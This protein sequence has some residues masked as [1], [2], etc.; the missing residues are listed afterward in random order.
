MTCCRSFVRADAV[1]GKRLYRGDWTALH[2]VPR[3]AVEDSVG[4]RC[5][6][7]P[8]RMAAFVDDTR[9]VASLILKM[10]QGVQ[11]QGDALVGGAVE[12]W[13]LTDAYRG[14]VNAGARV[15]YQDQQREF[16]P[17]QGLK[18]RACMVKEQ[19]KLAEGGVQAFAAESSTGAQAVGERVQF[20][21]AMA[22]DAGRAVASAR[23]A[24]EEYPDDKPPVLNTILR[25]QLI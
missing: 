5:L 25:L 7:P 17:V 6:S 12:A 1:K 18:D 16:N 13:R 2:F 15:A 24:F 23:V 19:D 8:E 3:K 22:D 21:Q 9:Q 11:S 20:D 14:A 4:N 10:R